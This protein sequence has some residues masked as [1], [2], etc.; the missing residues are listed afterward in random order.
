VFALPRVTT[1]QNSLC[2]E[3]LQDL[4]RRFGIRAFVETGTYLG[5]T[6]E[7]AAEI[8][9]EVHTIELSAELAQQATARL[10][11]RK[12]VR[13]Y[14]GDSSERL[15][16]ILK[17][18]VGPALFWLDGHWSMGKTAKGKVNTPILEE[19]RAI[20]ESG[21]RNAVILIDDLR[22]FGKPTRKAD[23]T[24][25]LSDYPDINELRQA[26]MALNGGYQFLVLGDVALAY[27]ASFDVAPSPVMMAMT[28]SRLFDGQN[29]TIAE[30]FEAEEV[31]S[32]AEGSERE[33][34]QALSSELS[35]VEGHGLG[36][37]YRFWR[38][39]T[40]LGEKKFME[41]AKQFA[42]VI[43]FGFGH[44]R[45][46]W[47]LALAL[48][49]AG[50]HSGAAELLDELICLLPSFAPA[51]SLRDRLLG[52]TAEPAPVAAPSP[53]AAV[54]L[55][56][57]VRVRWGSRRIPVKALPF[58]LDED[59]NRASETLSRA[60]PGPEFEALCQANTNAPE[61]LLVTVDYG[62]QREQVAAWLAA[63]GYSL[64]LD[65]DRRFI[66]SRLRH[67]ADPALALP[68]TKNFVGLTGKPG[69][70]EIQKEAEHR[71]HE[72]IKKPAT[73]VERIVIVG[74][75]LGFEVKSF[76]RNYPKA[77]IHVFEPS[78]RY[79]DRLRNSYAN[80]PRVICHRYA[81]GDENGEVTF[82]EGTL[83]G[84]GSLLPFATQANRQT[85]IPDQCRP[86]ETYQVPVVT[87][88]SFPPLRD[89]PIDLLWCDV[90]GA[91]LK[92]L[93]G[94]Q[95]ALRTCRALFLE[96][97]TTKMSY[98][99]QC[100]L[101]ELE[102]FCLQRGF[103]LAGIG[104]CP[105]GNGTGN[106]MWLRTDAQA[107]TPRRPKIVGLVVGR[108][109]A[110][111]LPFCLRALAKYTDAI[112]YL[113]D[114][115]EDNSVEVVR[116]LSAECRVERILRKD[117]W[118]LDEPGD[119]NLLLNGGREIGGTH[120]I[121]IDVD[122]A[123]TSNCAE[124]DFLR[125][126]ILSL[127]PGD[128]IA[129]NWIQLW[130]DVHQYR[131]DSSVWTW[132]Y[133]GVIFCDDGKC[134]HS[135]EFVHTP[136]V[137]ANLSGQCYRLPGYVHGL[138]H[139]QFVNWRNLLVK[140]AWYR[141]L[142][143]VRDA[144]KPSS[145][146]NERYAPSKDEKGLGVWAA[147]AEW[148]S[149]YP[150]FDI[151]PF[152]EPEWWREKQVRQWFKQLGKK[153]FQD[154]DI[155]DLD[156]S[157]TRV[158]D[159]PS[160]TFPVT[161]PEDQ[162]LRATAFV[163]EAERLLQQG[164]LAA[165]RG[166]LAKAL[167]YTPALVDLLVWVGKLS[168]QLGDARTARWEFVKATTLNPGHVSAW[169]KLAAAAVSLDRIEEF[170]TA[171]G[172]AMQLEPKNPEA[173]KLLGDLHLT[174]SQFIEAARCYYQIL[175]QTPD[176]VDVLL[177]LGVCLYKSGDLQTA[178][179]VYEQVL[180]LAPGHTLAAENLAAVNRRFSQPKP[181]VLPQAPPVLGLS[182]SA[183]AGP[184]PLVSAIVSTY[185]SER[186]I[187]GCLEDL[188]GQTLF[189]HGQLEIVVVDTGS[190]QN[191]RAIVEE[192]QGRYP[193]I[194][195]LRTEQRE[196]IYAAWNRGIVAA[197]G[198]YITN[199]NTDDRHR[200]DGLEVMANYLEAH[201]EI[202]L[203]YADQLISDVPNETFAETQAS[204]RWNWPDYSYAELER[205]CIIGPQP[206]W[207]RQLHEKHGLFL[208]ELHSAGDYEFWLRIGKSEAF[209]RLPD[210]LGLYYRN[211]GGDELSAGHSARET[212]EVR[213]RYGILARNVADCCSVPTAVSREELNRLP[214][215]T[216]SG[217]SLS[218]PLP[219][220][221]GFDP[222][223]PDF[224]N[225]PVSPSRPS[226]AYCP[227]DLAAR[228][229]VTIVTP[230]FNTGDLFE[231]TA[232]S[233]LRQSFQQWE[234]LIVND[235]STTPEAA[236]VL[237]RYRQTDPRITVLDQPANSG[238]GAARNR[239]VQ[240]AAGDYIVLLDSDDLLE[241][242]AIEKWLWFLESHPEHAFVKGFSVGFGAKNY[243][244]ANGFHNR[245]AFLHQN[246]VD[247][248]SMIRKPV[249][250]QVGGYEEQMR[251]GFED[252]EFWLRCAN[253]GLWGATIP[254]F[255]DWYRRRDN[256][257]DRWSNWDSG[258]RQQAARTDL[259]Q[260]YQRLQQE[261]PSSK[262][263][264]IE[265]GSRLSL[266]SAAEN[267]LQ[268][269][270]PRIL[271]LLPWMTLGGADKFNLDLVEQ[272]TARG[273]E[274]TCATTL[275]GDY[276]WMPEFGRFTP[277]VFAL[278]HFLEIGDY[279]RFLS[280]LIQSRQF[281]TV[282]ISNSMM[283]YQLLPFLRS[284]FP[285]VTF[286]DYCHMEQSDWIDGGYPRL[287][288]QLA[289][290][291]DLSVVSSSHLKNWMVKQK[292]DAEQ[293]EVCYTNINAKAWEPSPAIRQR[294]RRELG[295]SESHPV[296][297]FAGRIVEQ[298]QPR[299]FAETMR[300][301]RAQHR[302]FT[303][304][305]AGDGPDLPWLKEFVTQHQLGKNVRL[306][307]GVPNQ[308]IRELMMAADIF[309]LP[310]QWEG[311]AL[312][313]F[314]AMACGLAVVGADVGGQRELV[315]PD[316][317]HL[318]PRADAISE[319]KAYAAVLAGLT[320]D[321]ERARTLGR[322]ARARITQEFALKQM[323]DRM[324]ALLGQA[325]RR[326]AASTRP[327]I[328]PEVGLANAAQVVEMSRIPSFVNAA[329][330]A[331]NQR[332]WH[333][334]LKLFQ[335][336]RS[337]AQLARNTDL[338]QAMD[339]EIAK[340]QKL[341]KAQPAKQQPIAAGGKFI[342]GSHRAATASPL[343]SVV[344]PCYNY[345][346]LLPEAVESVVQQTFRN[347]EIIIVNDGSTDNTVEVANRLI[348]QHGATQRL[349]LVSQPNSGQ[350]AAARNAGIAAATGQYIL[351]LD[352][353]DKIAPTF[354]EQTVAVLQAA[355]EVGVAYTHIQHFGAV[356]GVYATGAFD[357]AV[358]AHD[359][360]LPY[361]SL[362]RRR[363]W[364]EAGG[365]RLM[366]YEDWD[367]WLTLAERG[368]QGRLIPQPLFWYRKHNRG[369]LN[370]DNQKREYLVATLVCNHPK[371][372]DDVRRQW[373]RTVLAQHCAANSAKRGVETENAS[374]VAADRPALRITYL[375]SSILGVTG[376]NQTLL[377]QA[378]EMRRRGHA[379]TIVTYTPKPDWF[380]FGTR[381]VQV[382]A[383]QPMAPCVPPSDIVVAT[384]FTNAP[385][386]AAVHAP[387]K[388]YYAQGDQFVFGD[389]TMPD[390]E[391]NRQL[392]E[393]SR[394]SYLLPSIRFVPNSRNLAAAV[395]ELC[396][397]RPDAIL[398]VC[399]DQTIFR[400]LQRSL[401]GSRF[402]LLIV[403]P[404]S[405]G[406]DAEPL[407]FKG[408]QDIH[409]ALQ[410][411]ARRFP[412]FTAV[413]MSSTPPEIF[414]RFPCEFYIAPADEMKTALFG[415]AHILI[416]ASHYDSCPRPPQEA[417]A[418]GCA[419]VCTATP[420]ALEYCRDGEN[421]LLVPVRSPDAIANAVER[422]IRDHAVRDKLVQ[423]G[424]ATARE[425]PREREWNEWEAMLLRF[426]EQAAGKN[427]P[428][429]KAKPAPGKSSVLAPAP[430][431]TGI[432]L[433]PCAL[434][435]QLGHA[436]RL[437]GQKQLRGAWAFT[438]AAVQSRP[439][440][441]E[442]YL[443]LAQIA[444][445]AGDAASSRRCAQHARS[446][447]P[448]WKPIKRFLKSNLRGN[449]KPDWLTLPDSLTRPSPLAPRLSVCLIVKNEEKFLAQC[450]TSVRGLA[451]QIV[452]VD[453]GSNDRT[454]AI[455]KE[456]GAEV[457]HFAWC[458]D[459]GA[460][461][462]AA[463]EHATG[464][465]ILMLDA[466][467][468]LP[469]ESHGALRKL[470]S[471]P[472]VMAWRL[473]IIDVGRE[474]E[475]CCYVP[476][477]FR[478]APALFYIGRVHEQ[479]FTSIEVRRQEWGL[480]SR[481][482][483]AALRH[484]GYLPEVVKDR[485]KIERNL[486]LLEKAIVELPDEPNLLMNYGLELVRSG[487]R[488]TGMDQYRKAFDLMSAQAPALVIP[489]TREM[490]LTQLCTQLVALRGFD[491][492]IRVLTSPLAQSGGLTASLHFSMGLAYLEVKQPREA[493]DQMRQCL[494]KRD[495][496][497]LAPINPEIRKAGPH[498]CLALSLTQLGESDAAA[499]EFRLAIKDDPQSRPARFDYA[500]FLATRNESVE[501]LNLLF[502]LANQK[503]D[504]LPVW[505]QGGQIA[506]SR[507]EF[508]EVALDWTAEAQR[509]FPEDRA[510]R[511]HRA[512]ALT[513]A[514]R[515]EEALPLWRQL[516]PESDPA[517][518]AALVLCE[519]VAND[520]QFLPPTHREAHISREFLQ[521]Y[522]RLIKFNGRPA[523]EAVNSRIESL[524]SRL[525]SVA[526]MLREALA[527]AQ[528]V[529][530]A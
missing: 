229:V 64:L 23:A 474:A 495:Q 85:W 510:I 468:E 524:Q 139:F 504:D 191:E 196:K 108:N 141:C 528:A 423:G 32:R 419:V 318:L 521:W 343:V 444:Q 89:K 357:P 370:N 159:L 2:S 407:L 131:R 33:L 180:K 354:L 516:S 187:R 426:V 298:K 46:R 273:W 160:A 99:G 105:S 289:S 493:A 252:W 125:R 316:C 261:F 311:I 155:W 475:G 84:V 272:L 214:C 530:P 373:G 201:P 313:I 27:P 456:H 93:R 7:A 287:S 211:P 349:R 448:A 511:R 299:V 203:V 512:E 317:G 194:R 212:R 352:A 441:P 414:S 115:S 282:L 362:Y 518:A 364:E 81:V 168:L 1:S 188:V 454:V 54:A 265:P 334:A 207:R 70:E 104:L 321:L 490:L 506:L 248:T 271:M 88:D 303:T 148:L 350:P 197:R 181:I 480:D 250:T 69:Y 51:R 379:V 331:A 109:E 324:V 304:L 236:R 209:H 323:G 487:Q 247:L 208:P 502:E 508:L 442:A 375:I 319:A 149:G 344:I 37:H 500:R 485:N 425:F 200:A 20:K 458:D 347:F 254:E 38:A 326:R 6:A 185:A 439:F 137:P 31:L 151:A 390:T 154:L 74:G 264:P 79:H 210:I 381:V 152:N 142:E 285:E 182:K 223:R 333:S 199:A 258:A 35:D 215:R 235:A 342:T 260:K 436:R 219:R 165:A 146:I 161:A 78:Q 97:A 402:R 491:E 198:K 279:P 399:T 98:Q 409:D 22:L 427:A 162:T 453:T 283:G 463:L 246:L 445:A 382:P 492:I 338:V 438:L 336:V 57:K 300:L 488:E 494:T 190:P 34:L 17:R 227:T 73:E 167:D 484:H 48:C 30:V 110:P 312:S 267:R 222:A 202:A 226:R 251:H 240:M 59:V 315:T 513:L 466:D 291:L 378:E 189:G 11:A 25:S 433:P 462:N 71:L 56:T 507:P 529:V 134:T 483:D 306:L 410:I 63:K 62:D 406:T 295:L 49:A 230:F 400:P 356:Q 233:V 394:A 368:C 118:H 367:F 527:Q 144:A 68:N 263:S 245:E 157:G 8:F 58:L 496:P 297:L 471:E 101:D 519:L 351:P 465:W 60:V 75:H 482:G 432:T 262:P 464:D 365:Y 221:A 123:F 112:V 477:L 65:Y 358:L 192:F 520:E 127:L 164:N 514:N 424:L 431:P 281:D 242:T 121:A 156:W 138:M 307:G 3:F 19:L 163:Q 43:Q 96:V 26:V 428:T 21:L 309:F 228:P 277:D 296:I 469:S 107:A 16:Q 128:Q 396:G 478:N 176:N 501:A 12:N 119:R 41:A 15:P 92:V 443:L 473:P 238:P 429:V 330:E 481:L 4:A 237:N 39:L 193:N 517:V 383:G 186:F 274:V 377:R 231:E 66:A 467:E 505:L 515:C 292:G 397:R 355:P 499:D 371:L 13:V 509:H 102:E 179:M 450:L 269:T 256:H 372:Y 44:W 249:F 132:N 392:R 90:Q 218:A 457:H 455:A 106:A 136:R 18:L 314:E 366:G 67:I 234:W 294:V 497:S 447:A 327:P 288:V 133:K 5:S 175:E 205:R 361:C 14:Q 135:S 95:Q 418:A 24:S 385:E 178:R 45:A 244:W 153:H 346:H 459:F 408:I 72:W 166:V 172:R 405:R 9:E 111:R 301:L 241:P 114:C 120:F 332:D 174:Q 398:P 308:R 143:R 434:L 498:H 417:M 422:L 523:I 150:F 206:M 232:Q 284:R 476:R 220:L 204:S 122:E 522:Q 479:V 253:H 380:Q 412:Q 55:P 255:L 158:P 259:Q 10:A 386:L 430:K 404:D 83:E 239:G 217:L 335:H 302:D 113:D 353:D 387:V 322:S 276:S 173:L 124:K 461:R 275:P 440:H 80:E 76:L 86:A 339:T 40:L 183:Q 393:L 50:Q 384:Y 147:P 103:F 395:E 452:V 278:P 437:F 290:C 305:V 460:A 268:K 363:L 140:Q 91:E 345:A 42:A 391:Q 184:P 116:S 47:Y 526:H 225:T 503:G 310:S 451:D 129:V 360:V 325:Y 413:R 126:L 340:T 130:R 389:A 195:Y 77:E 28:L 403:G 470:L 170:E 177:C 270:H 213:E 449:A 329:V 243:L 525:P 415:T 52:R 435:G 171:L 216:R 337:L 87:L 280:Y 266:N 29:L 369:M 376:G 446:L 293:I 421:A 359:N 224:A 169:V 486:R 94:G 320:A 348:Q 145:A 53:N 489:E 61:P 82:H 117:R 472:A 286:L 100:S 388:V 401:P 411:L 341:A 416:Y 257:N 36:L 420:G 328:P 374:P